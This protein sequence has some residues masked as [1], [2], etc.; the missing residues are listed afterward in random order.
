MQLMEAIATELNILT[1]EPS[2]GGWA[3]NNSTLLFNEK[4]G[5]GIYIKTT[6]QPKYRG[7]YVISGFYSYKKADGKLDN[8]KAYYSCYEELPQITVSVFKSAAEIALEIKNRFLPSYSALFEKGKSASKKF[9]QLNK[10]KEAIATLKKLMP[11]SNATTN[12]LSSFISTKT[13]E[14]AVDI[15]IPTW[16]AEQPQFYLTIGSLQTEQVCKLVQMLK[17]I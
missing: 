11:E 12:R 2:I 1:G 8:L 6:T 13:Q 17:E 5:Y 15:R 9:E 4:S 10:D 7:C 3:V 14:I 16:R